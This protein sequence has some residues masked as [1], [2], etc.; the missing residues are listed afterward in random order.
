MDDSH[1]E[2]Y[3]SATALYAASEM[4]K[5]EFGETQPSL[6]ELPT[7]RYLQHMLNQT[8]QFRLRVQTFLMNISFFLVLLFM[9]ALFV[10]YHRLTRPTPQ[11]LET[12]RLIEHQHLLEAVRRVH[13]RKS[14]EQGKLP[15]ML[16]NLPLFSPPPHSLFLAKGH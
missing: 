10:Y 12:Q 6:I 4:K 1:Q 9:F 13:E 3:T 8:Y 5:A 7:Q 14:M 2:E 15:S 11:E 16:T